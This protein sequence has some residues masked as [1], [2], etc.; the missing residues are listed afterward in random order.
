MDQ[1]DPP[2]TLE[3][4]EDL[5]RDLE[6][7]WNDPETDVL[8]K[9]RIV[10]T[11]IQDVIADVDS[12]AGEIILVI[13]WKGGVHTELRLPRRGQAAHTSGEIVA[14]ARLLARICSDDLIAGVLN[15]NGLRT[16]R[17]NRWTRER[18]TSLR[19]YHKIPCYCPETRQ[20]QGWMN[21]SE[22]AKHLDISTRTLR[23]AVEQGKIRGEHPLSDGPWVFNRRDLE[24]EAAREIVAR[25]KNRK[26][27]PAVPDPEQQSLPFSGT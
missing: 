21:L 3:E 18:V 19:S 5:A 22:A 1:Q 4:F 10:R 9:K 17:G 14:A 20:Q 25:A 24:T 2:G 12:E 6:V 16:G 8:L 27:N 15:R 7:V 23:R 11:L 26:G 13:H